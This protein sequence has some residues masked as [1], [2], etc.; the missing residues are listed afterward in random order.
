ML[1]KELLTLN[2]AIKKLRR[3]DLPTEVVAVFGKDIDD[4]GAADAKGVWRTEDDVVELYYA[5]DSD[6][7]WFTMALYWNLE[8]K[9]VQDT[10]YYA[11]KQSLK[12]VIQYAAN[13]Y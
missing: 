4:L 7:Q 9:Q 6:G 10:E 5:K 3:R 12:D 11:G 13:Q 1:L 2:E 8:F